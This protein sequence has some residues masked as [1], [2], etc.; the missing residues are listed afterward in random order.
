MWRKQSPGVR[1]RVGWPDCSRTFPA[2]LMFFIVSRRVILCGVRV[3]EA[4]NPGPLFSDDELL[5]P[6]TVPDEVFDALEFDLT[7]VARRR[8][9]RSVESQ[10]ALAES[11]VRFSV[12]LDSEGHARHA[13]VATTTSQDV[14]SVIPVSDSNSQ[15]EVAS[16]GPH[17][18]LDSGE[19]NPEI[20]VEVPV[21]SLAFAAAARAALVAMDSVDLED[22][23]LTRASVIQCVPAFLRCLYRASM[24]E[25]N[26]AREASDTVAFSR[27]WKLFLILPRLLLH[28]PPRSGNI[29]KCKLLQRFSDFA[30]G[31]WSYL[32]EESR[33]FAVMSRRRRRRPQGDD[34]RGAEWVISPQD[35]LPSKV[36]PSLLAMRLHDVLWW[37]NPDAHQS[38]MN[39]SVTTSSSVEA[40]RSLLTTTPSQR[41][42]GSHG[43]KQQLV[44]PG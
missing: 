23:F 31:R 5:I 27:A 9:L 12:L 3:G 20:E 34:V 14:A 43:K 26:K 4:L 29:P 8:R 1:T 7:P 18:D 42:F 2:L 35:A 40:R 15:V 28:R 11:L 10:S 17:S 44:L 41:T 30:A 25:A 19:A 32:M 24:I 38:S 39:P 21:F 37:M 33:D 13:S 36:L 16:V 6:P 22:E